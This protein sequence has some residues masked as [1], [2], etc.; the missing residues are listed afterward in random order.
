MEADPQSPPLWGNLGDAGR[1]E[2]V[3]S[4]MSECEE[5]GLVDFFF[6]KAC[7]NELL[8][9]KKGQKLPSL[10]ICTGGISLWAVSLQVP[11]QPLPG[12][13]MYKQRINSCS[14]VSLIKKKKKIPCFVFLF[15]FCINPAQRKH[16]RLLN[17]AGTRAGPS[18]HSFKTKYLEGI[19]FQKAPLFKAICFKWPLQ[20]YCQV[21]AC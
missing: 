18:E 7:L 11:S 3:S 2:S 21:R 15:Y 13:S 6:P 20:L 5:G 1:D 17:S 12:V 14:T 4:S 16:G 19:S 9:C 10:S 8:S